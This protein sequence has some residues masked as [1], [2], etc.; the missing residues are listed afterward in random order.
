MCRKTVFSN[1]SRT[2]P[3]GKQTVHQ[4][5]SYTT[6]D[7]ETKHF[8][9]IV[10]HS[11]ILHFIVLHVITEFISEIQEYIRSQVKWSITAVFY[12]TISL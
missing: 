6:G 3:V 7:T 9:T 4:N 8:Q 2:A 10:L 5:T 1:I 12:S 11:I